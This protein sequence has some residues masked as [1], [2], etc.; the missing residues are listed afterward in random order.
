MP[1]KNGFT[2][3][4]RSASLTGYA[5]LARHHGLNPE[6][7]MRK[8][9]LT[10]R[11]LVDPDMPISPTAVSQLLEDS[12]AQAGVEDFGLQ[13]AEHRQLANLGPISLVMREAPSARLALDNLCRYMRLINAALLTS[14]EDFGDTVVIRVELLVTGKRSVRQSV[15]M[16]VGV[17]Y[18]AIGE[19][20][21]PAWR[22][23][24][25]GFKHRQPY[26][27]THHKA[28]FRSSVEFNAGFNG[29]VCT[30]RDLD[31]PIAAGDYHMT[32]HVQRLLDHALSG[33]AESVT[34][35]VRQVVIAML[36]G[37]R[38]TSDQVAKHL[39]VDRRTL[40]RHLAAEG[41][42]YFA[43]HQSIRAELAARQILDSDRSL[44]ELA[45][46]L[47]FSSSSAFA[48][49]FRKQFGTTVS[50]WKKGAQEAANTSLNGSVS[51]ST[52]Q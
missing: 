45:D 35:T 28:L 42:S 24:S 51:V 21:G 2:P 14:I 46:L 48:F 41:T 37:G 29:I 13:L 1:A 39:G 20:L 44:A 30:A 17:M 50:S 12:A 15:E 52:Q 10:S 7:M 32:P 5:E 49:W 34:H 26:G 38:C 40:H 36:P 33:S 8:V 18:R 25:I 47:G 11:S 22:A 43:L 4:I 19:L 6:A 9:G 3:L 27:A 16:A 23:R 31:A